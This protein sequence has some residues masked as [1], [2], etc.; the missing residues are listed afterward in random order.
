MTSLVTVREH[1]DVGLIMQD[2]YGLRLPTELRAEFGGVI[3]GR[4]DSAARI[5]DLFDEE[6]LL[7][8]PASA[9]LIRCAA[10]RTHCGLSDPWIGLY[11]MRQFIDGPEKDPSSA[12]ARTL[13]ARGVP[14]SVLGRYSHTIEASG[15]AAVYLHC[16]AGSRAWGVGIARESGAATLKALLSAVNRADRTPRGLPTASALRR[17]LPR[18]R[19]R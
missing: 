14:V 7:R 1:L 13:T 2:T 4:A 3:E 11:M 15:E 18:T 5:R 19:F 10:R 9:L 12:L 16:L 6:Y 8:E 17:C